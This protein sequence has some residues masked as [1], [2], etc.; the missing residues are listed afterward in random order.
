M[1]WDDI[2]RHFPSSDPSLIRA[3]FEARDPELRR[4]AVEQF[5]GLYLKPLQVYL[6]QLGV[7]GEEVG[8]RA[9]S[10]PA[11]P[12]RLPRVLA[13]VGKEPWEGPFARAVSN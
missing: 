7:H 9:R 6:E 1:I 5:I 8:S 3:A 2:L 10:L 4:K 13:E 12:R 11:L